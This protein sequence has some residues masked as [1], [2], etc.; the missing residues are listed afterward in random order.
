M[1]RFVISA[2]VAGHALLL[3]T[4]DLRDE[5]SPMNQGSRADC[6]VV[7][8]NSGVKYSIAGESMAHVGAN[9]K[10]PNMSWSKLIV[11]SVMWEVHLSIN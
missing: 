4:R 10:W 11:R 2:A 3:N 1:D 7:I 6:V 5:L 8:A 9:L